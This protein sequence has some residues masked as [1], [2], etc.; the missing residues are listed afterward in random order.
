VRLLQCGERLD[1]HRD[2]AYGSDQVEY[3]VDCL[4][5]LTRIHGLGLQRQE[6]RPRG[7]DETI[8]VIEI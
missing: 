3:E 1:L 4:E 6:W 7:V 8:T 5:R 2:E